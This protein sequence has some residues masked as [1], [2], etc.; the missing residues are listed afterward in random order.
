MLEFGPDLLRDVLLLYA[1]VF[2]YWFFDVRWTAFLEDKH[3]IAHSS[4]K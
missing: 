1:L 3:E 2:S 4:A